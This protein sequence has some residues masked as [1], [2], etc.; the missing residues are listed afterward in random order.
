MTKQVTVAMDD[1]RA[2]VVSDYDFTRG[3]SGS[4]LIRPDS[5]EVTVKSARWVAADGTATICD[6]DSIHDG[7]EYDAILLACAD[8]YDADVYEAMGGAEDGE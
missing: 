6:L 4:R 5:D 8:A 3:T 2:L 7:L 1:G